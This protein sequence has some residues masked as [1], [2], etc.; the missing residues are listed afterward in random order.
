MKSIFL[1]PEQV[2]EKRLALLE[3]VGAAAPAS[4]LALLSC[5]DDG[6][7]LDSGAINYYL[8]G[9]GFADRFGRSNPCAVCAVRPVVLLDA[10]EEKLLRRVHSE[11]GIPFAEF[12]TYPTTVLDLSLRDMA[13]KEYARGALPETGRTVHVAGKP[14]PVYRLGAKQIIRVVLAQGGVNGFREL[15]EIRRKRRRF[16][17]GVILSERHEVIIFPH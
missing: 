12:G 2:F 11:G 5:V 6:F 8:S 14:A 17:F 15:C 3:N 16:R 9:G 10:G 1:S 7:L 4:D 13:E